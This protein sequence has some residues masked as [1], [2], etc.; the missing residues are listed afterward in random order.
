MSLSSRNLVLLICVP[1]VA[2]AFVA[3]R[4]SVGKPEESQERTSAGKAIRGSISP[5]PSAAGAR[6]AGK[7]PQI[8]EAN[9]KP[10]KERLASVLKERNRLARLKRVLDWAE[11]I[12]EDNWRDALGVWLRSGASAGF[13]RDIEARVV[14]ER[15]GAVGGAEAI[16][17]MESSSRNDEASTWR[18]RQGMAGWAS[19][20]PQDAMDYYLKSGASPGEA[21]GGLMEG[22]T[23]SDLKLARELSEQV[24][25]DWRDEHF[26]GIMENMERSGEGREALKAWISKSIEENKDPEYTGQLITTYAQR[27]L[28]LLQAGGGNTEIFDWL[29]SQHTFPGTSHEVLGTAAVTLG[30]SHP[31]E[32]LNWLSGLTPGAISPETRDESV[33]GIVE[34][35]KSIRPDGAAEWLKA[36]PRHPLHDAVQ[37]ALTPRPA[38]TPFVDGVIIEPRS[39]QRGTQR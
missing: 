23:Q 27:E 3:G 36:N 29:A 14:M 38:A 16:D 31:E 2:M 22:L 25:E 18:V 26:R 33:A 24:L 15:I 12:D 28:E 8:A 19:T 10:S 13:G 39:P 35:W 7:A 34:E 21:R 32:A 20:H 11:S 4:W 5:A 1:A 9:A 17:A 37:L 6:T 30:H